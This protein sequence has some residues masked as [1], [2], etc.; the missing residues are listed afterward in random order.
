MPWSEPTHR[1]APARATCLGM[2]RSRMPKS[3]GGV[4]A[5]RPRPIENQ[6]SRHIGS[7]RP[8]AAIA[9]PSG[10]FRASQLEGLISFSGAHARSGE[11]RCDSLLT[12]LMTS[13]IVMTFCPP[14]GASARGVARAGRVAAPACAIRNRILGRPAGQSLPGVL[15]PRRSGRCERES[16]TMPRGAQMGAGRFPHRRRQPVCAGRPEQSGPVREQSRAS[17]PRRATPSHSG[18][19][20]RAEVGRTPAPKKQQGPISLGCLT[21]EDASEY[22]AAGR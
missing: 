22:P 5:A 9:M 7:T 14:R 1:P 11:R 10:T 17:A 20:K 3:R 18:E 4:A 19:G 15:R 13:H 21:I 12:R 2:I 16:G 8:S 6:G